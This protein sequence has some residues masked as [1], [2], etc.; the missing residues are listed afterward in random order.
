[1]T[2]PRDKYLALGLVLYA[3]VCTAIGFAAG[4]WFA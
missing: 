4:V 2:T 3:A 1:M